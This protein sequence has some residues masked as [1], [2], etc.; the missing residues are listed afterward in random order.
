MANKRLLKKEISAISDALFAEALFSI[1]QRPE[2]DK[3]KGEQLLS[4]IVRLNEEFVRRA[5]RP[6]G[7]GNRSIVKQYYRKLVDDLVV[8]VES[9]AGEINE[10][11][12]IKEA[13]A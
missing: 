10:L 12:G 11:S 8:E 5:H 3:E 1:L 7:N 4:R 6:S 2:S 9:I 13:E